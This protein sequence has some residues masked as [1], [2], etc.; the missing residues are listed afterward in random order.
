[1][2]RLPAAYTD[3]T[4]SFSK[5]IS[6]LHAS[7]RENER[8]ARL[9][10]DQQAA[11]YWAERELAFQEILHRANRAALEYLQAWAGVTRIGYHGARVDGREPGA[12]FL[13]RAHP[14]DVLQRRCSAC[15]QF[16]Q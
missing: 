11:V 16:R 10:G 2:N 1:M 3:V 9:A 8:R 13:F 12:Y 7:I 5:S 6:I 4:I 14:I 15:R